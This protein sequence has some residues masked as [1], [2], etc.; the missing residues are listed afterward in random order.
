MICQVK[1]SY[2]IVLIEERAYYE[3]KCHEMVCQNAKK[4]RVVSGEDLL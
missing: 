1:M 3:R 4:G 2:E